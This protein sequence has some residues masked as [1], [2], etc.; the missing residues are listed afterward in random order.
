MNRAALVMLAGTT[1]CLCGCITP[2]NQREKALRIG[3]ERCES[4]G[5]QFLLRSQ[6]Q[7]GN[8]ITGLETVVQ[9]ACVGP[10]EEGYVPPALDFKPRHA[11]VVS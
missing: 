11:S 5:K 2:E 7:T 9:Y 8:V 1:A 6:E 4:M 3:M 10:G